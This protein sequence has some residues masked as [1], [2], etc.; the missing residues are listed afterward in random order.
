MLGDESQTNLN[1]RVCPAKAFPWNMEELRALIACRVISKRT[2]TSGGRRN[3]QRTIFRSDIVRHVD[4]V[5]LESEGVRI[6]SRMDEAYTPSR[7]LS[8]CS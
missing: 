3:K 2:Y 7:A 5:E 1:A 6:Y 4:G 8:R